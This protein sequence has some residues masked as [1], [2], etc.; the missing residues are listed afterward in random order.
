MTLRNA[1]KKIEKVFGKVNITDRGR[2]WIKYNN[3]ELSYCPNGRIE[4][5]TSICCIRT[6]RINDKDDIITDYFAGSF[7]NNLTKAI[8]FI[9]LNH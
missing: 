9:N 3:Y 4:L 5:D 1:D 2:R 7:H 8:N 6:R